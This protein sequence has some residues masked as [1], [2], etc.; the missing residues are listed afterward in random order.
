MQC[1]DGTDCGPGLTCCHTG[2]SVDFLYACTKRHGPESRCAMEICKPDGARC[3]RGSHCE[4]DYCV[5]DHVAT[6]PTSDQRTCEKNEYCEWKAGL[7]SCVKDPAPVESLDE[8]RGV[9]ACTRARDCAA[10]S[11]C[12]TSMSVFW[13]QTYCSTNCDVSNTTFPCETAADCRAKLLLVPPSLRHLAKL[14]CKPL[15]GEG[16][17]WLKVCELVLP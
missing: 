6:C 15:E 5:S 16:P 7:A 12:C 17:S 9:F 4:D 14:E 3:P 1:D 8:A 10:G 11:Q 2:A 13:R